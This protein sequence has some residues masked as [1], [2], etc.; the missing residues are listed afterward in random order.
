MGDQ[1]HP[2]VQHMF[3]HAFHASDLTSSHQHQ[4]SPI[5]HQ[6]PTAGHTCWCTNLTMIHPE[7]QDDS[8]KQQRSAEN[9]VD[10]RQEQF[11]CHLSDHQLIMTAVQDADA[12]KS[13]SVT[14]G[15]GQLTWLRVIAATVPTPFGD[16]LLTLHS[17]VDFLHLKVSCCLGPMRCIAAHL[18]KDSAPATGKKAATTPA[19]LLRG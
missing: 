2:S 12:G 13:G 15:A 11:P 14:P 16:G 4:V 5:W 6:A 10:Q 18:Y 17:S 19:F 8:H 7:K 9:E 1:V 3:S